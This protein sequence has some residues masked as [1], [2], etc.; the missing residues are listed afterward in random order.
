MK[1]Q[2]AVAASAGS[3]RNDH[4]PHQGLQFVEAIETIVQ[5]SYRMDISP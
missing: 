1:F 2:A 5:L 4:T 3:F